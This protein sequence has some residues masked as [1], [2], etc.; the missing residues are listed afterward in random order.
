MASNAYFYRKKTM[1]HFVLSILV[2][3]IHFRVFSVY[4]EDALLNEA[5]RLFSPLTEVAVPLFFAISGA[6]FYR[7]Y[8][9]SGTIKK[10]KNRF[11]SLLVPYLL[12]NSIWL[13]LAL[14]GYY[15]P[16][17]AVLGGV[18]TAFSWEAVFSGVFLYGYLE[19]FWFVWQLIVLTLCCPLI[20]LLL[21]N[22]WVGLL[23]IAGFYVACCLGME[24]PPIF[25]PAKHKILFYLVGAWVGMHHFEVFS[26]RRSKKIAVG[27][28]L[29]FLAVLYGG[30][31]LP[32]EWGMW[33]QLPLMVMACGAFWLAFDAFEMKKIPAF[34][35]DSFL[36]Y[37]LHSFVGAA[38]SKL[39]GFLPVPLNALVTFPCT[40]LIICVF[41]NLLGRFTPKIKGLLTG[42][43]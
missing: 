40:V 16:L 20:Y 6:L 24:F 10:W 19:P 25:F 39:L 9:L 41:G 29:L 15:T 12:W 36:I 23:A 35:A 43:S 31:C 5:F 28:F 42:R 17:G 34:T 13:C 8:S 11:F 33:H 14:L 4:R 27:G 38:L 32:S 21:K 37:A 18:K 7:N 1:V 3:F 22:K 30:A 26:A 2:F